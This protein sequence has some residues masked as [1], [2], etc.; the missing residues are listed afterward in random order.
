MDRM[1]AHIRFS[2]FKDYRTLLTVNCWSFLQ[3]GLLRNVSIYSS[4]VK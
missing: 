3:I 1:I 2:Y 4:V